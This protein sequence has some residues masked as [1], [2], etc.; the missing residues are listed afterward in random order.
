MMA[1]MDEVLPQVKTNMSQDELFKMVLSVFK[2]NIKDQQGPWNQKEMRYY[3]SYYGFPT[4][5][6]EN[7]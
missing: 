1:V 4:T 6:K 7:A 3:G 5:L 2:Y